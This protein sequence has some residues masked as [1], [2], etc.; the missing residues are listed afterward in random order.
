MMSVH[1]SFLCLPPIHHQPP[2]SLKD[3]LKQHLDQVMEE[4][5]VLKANISKEKKNYQTANLVQLQ[6]VG[7]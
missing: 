7:K 4:N 1:L 3:V 2:Q 5:G 6:I